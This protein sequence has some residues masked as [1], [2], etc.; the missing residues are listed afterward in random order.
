VA[1]IQTA[2]RKFVAPRHCLTLRAT[3]SYN[4]TGSSSDSNGVVSI[5]TTAESAEEAA[6]ARGLIVSLG[7]RKF[8]S[9]CTI[10]KKSQL[11]GLP[12]SLAC[13]LGNLG[14]MLLPAR[15][16]SMASGDQRAPV[17]SA[18]TSRSSGVQARVALP[19]VRRWNALK[20]PTLTW[21]RAG[22]PTAD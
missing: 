2:A 19:P 21:D 6:P 17:A 11:L 12:L 7:A 3:M 1:A 14:F 4:I 13:N 16:P 9:E 8:T 18:S 5:S 15:R 20:V 10:V 22:T